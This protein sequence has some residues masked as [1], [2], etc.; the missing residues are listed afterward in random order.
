[1]A[2]KLFGIEF[3]CEFLGFCHIGNIG[4]GIIVTLVRYIVLIKDGFHQFPAVYVNLDVKWEPCLG[5]YKHEPELLIQ[6][7]KV[8]MEAFGI[9]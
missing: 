8:I 6:I 5:L 4:E 9:G 3:I 2:G 1:M 7:V